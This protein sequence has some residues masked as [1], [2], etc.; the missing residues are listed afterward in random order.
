MTATIVDTS[1]L[2]KMLWTAAVAGV[3]VTTMFAI[4]VV[5][6]TRA[7][8]LSRDDRPAEAAILGAVGALA[9]AAVGAAVVY[10]IVVMIQK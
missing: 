2:L 7:L 6:A 4:G 3:G 10:G 9:L 1:A 5:G 8:D